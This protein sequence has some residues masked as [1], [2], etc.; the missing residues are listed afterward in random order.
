[1]VVVDYEYKVR[2]QNFSPYTT[3]QN[4]IHS[5]VQGYNR[6]S[7]QY[8]LL[9]LNARFKYVHT[10]LFKLSSTLA[11]NNSNVLTFDGL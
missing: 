2:I 7:S 4:T 5:V 1:M 3:I 8:C 11:N 6:H 9:S 10:L